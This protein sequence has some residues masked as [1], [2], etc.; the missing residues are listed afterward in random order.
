MEATFKGG[1]DFYRVVEPMMMMMMIS[2]NTQIVTFELP[3]AYY[4]ELQQS[5][6]VR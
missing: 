1:Q 5:I 2:Y 4:V 6:L 3:Q